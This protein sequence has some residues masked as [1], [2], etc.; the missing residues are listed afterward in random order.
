MM[1]LQR[2]GYNAPRHARSTSGC[3]SVRLIINEAM[4]NDRATSA[5]AAE[6]KSKKR[7]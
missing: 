1:Q 3:A 7:K 2:R 4:S 6:R 5:A